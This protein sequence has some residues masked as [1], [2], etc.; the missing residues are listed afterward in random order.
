MQQSRA[1]NLLGARLSTFAT[2]FNAH[3]CLIPITQQ[4]SERMSG[5]PRGTQLVY[6]QNWSL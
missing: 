4:D 2:P 6:G 5:P 3:K 1:E